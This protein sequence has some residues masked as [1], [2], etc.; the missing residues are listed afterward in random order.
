MLDINFIRQHPE[1]VKRAIE[2]KYSKVDLGRLLEVDQRR[3]ELFSQVELLRAERNKVAQEKNI[4]RGRSIK[5]ELD[6]LETELDIVTEEFNSMMIQLPNIPDDDVP[7][8]KDAADNVVVRKWGEVRSFDFEVRDHIELGKLLDVIDCE[9]AGK[10]SGARFTYLKNEAVTLQFALISYAFSVLQ[11]P[12]LLKEIAAKVSPTLSPKTFV[13]VLPPVMIRPE[14]YVKMAR[15]DPTQAEERYHL[16]V[17]NL[18]LIGSAEHTLGPMH[19]DQVIDQKKLPL[20]YVGYSTSFRREAGS[21]GQDVKGILRMHQFD[22]I[23]IESFTLAEDSRKEQDFIV[24]IQEHLM[25]SLQLPYQVVMVGTGDMGTPDARQIDIETWIPSQGKY[26]ETHSSDL[27]TDFQ[28]RRLG[29]KVKRED[30]KN[31]LVHMND[32]TVFAIGRTEIAILENFQQA[33][34]SVVVPEVL[35]PYTG[36]TEIKPKD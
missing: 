11:N 22:K 2:L 10:V 15:L 35:I 33:D 12:G 36:F 20:R 1:K 16:S 30:G 28:S 6:K 13:P 34:G 32:A 3:R 8:G 5:V 19:M 17:D 14:V 23:E 26:R 9:T 29:T 18:Y 4:E 7:I 24:A 25:Q 27:V 21:Y 31:E